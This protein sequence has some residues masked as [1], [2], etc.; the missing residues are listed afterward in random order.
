M[1]LSTTADGIEEM[2][3]SGSLGRAFG[4]GPALEAAGWTPETLR[5]WRP[6]VETPE[7]PY[8]GAPNVFMVLGSRDTVTPFERGIALAQRWRVPEGNLHVREQ[9]HF[10]VPAGLMVDDRP[11]EAFARALGAP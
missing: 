5:R 3:I 7:A 9:G 4:V 10:S 1:L 2:G 8:M 11:I 6:L